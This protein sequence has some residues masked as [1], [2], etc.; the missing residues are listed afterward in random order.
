[1]ASRLEQL[2]AAPDQR[3]D[4]IALH[5]RRLAHPLT[6]SSLGQAPVD[7]VE[8]FGHLEQ[9]ANVFRAVAPH[10]IDCPRGDRRLLQRLDRG[11]AVAVALLAQALR[12]LVALLRELFEWE[13]VEPVDVGAVGLGHA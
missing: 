10:L 13:R 7:A 8:L 6:R 11:C 1:V 5:L 12:E 2:L 3:A 9:A 4:Q